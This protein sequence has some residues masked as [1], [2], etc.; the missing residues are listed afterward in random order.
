MTPNRDWFHT[1]EPISGGTVFM[2]DNHV[3][4]IAGIGTIKLKMY[5]GLI[6]TISGVR[7]VKDLKNNL[8]SVG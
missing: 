4:E 3:L 8:L 6:R 1:Y 7:H 2:S 5:D